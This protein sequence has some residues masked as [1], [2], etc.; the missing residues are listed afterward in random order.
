MTDNKTVPPPERRSAVETG[1]RGI[2]VRHL[3]KRYGGLI[4]VNDASFDVPA[5]AV[6]GFLGP[7]GSGKTTTMRSMLALT[8]PN[9]GTTLFDGRTIKQIPNPARTIGAVLDAGWLHSG[10]TVIE[11]LRLVCLTT[12]LA[13]SR[14]E[15]ML[16]TVGLTAVRQRRV[17]KLSLGMRQRLALA[18]VLAPDPA[19]LMLDE[20]MNGLDPEGINWLR[21]L[22]TGL[23]RAGRGILVSTHMIA[24]I[25]DLADNVVLIDRG[26]IIAAQRTADLLRPVGRTETLVQS[27]DDQRLAQALSRDG[28][29]VV[30]EPPYLRCACEAALIGRTAITEGIVL[31]ELRPEQ[32]S[33]REYVLEN[34]SGEFRA[35]GLPGSPE[36]EA[37]HGN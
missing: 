11:T 18:C 3:T 27:Q 22:M 17:G 35:P 10:R 6:T 2:A 25:D 9:S 14:P 20:P 21:T 16:E 30:A 4:A 34:T 23:A 28:V 8:Q 12:G 7:N 33:L 29:R 32:T 1:Q 37:S 26:R 15:E 19:Y 36:S 24:E 5:G 13:K 31:L